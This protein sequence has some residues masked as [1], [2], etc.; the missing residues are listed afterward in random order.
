VEEAD[1]V[2]GVLDQEAETLLTLA[3]GLLGPLALGDVF[4]NV[5]RPRAPP[6][7]VVQRLDV[8]AHDDASAV[9]LLD[10]D[11]RVSRR[12]AIANA[13]RYGR[14]IVRQRRPVRSPQP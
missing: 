9:R 4:K 7:L 10:D 13:G 3:Q 1:D 8:H 12:S 11:F 6:L 14:S 2:G 5:D